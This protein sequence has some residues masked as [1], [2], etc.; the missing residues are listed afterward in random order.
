MKKYIILPIVLLAMFIL[1][2]CKHLDVEEL[3]DDTMAYD[4]LFN[5]YVNLSKYMYGTAAMFPDEG[6]I[7]GDG[8]TPG[9]LATDEGFTSM[10]KA[11]FTGLGYVLGDFDAANISS[12]PMSIW[13]DMYKIIRKSNII[14]QRKGEAK[15]TS[16]EDQE[17]TG[18]THFI[19]GY[20]YYQLLMAYGPVIL[21]KDQVYPT[22]EGAAVYNNSRSTY[23]ECVD[24]I[25]DEFELAAKNIPVDITSNFFGRPGRGA[26]FA[27]IARL[28]LQ[29][30]SPLFN[31]GQ[32]A[33]TYFGAWTRKDGVHYISQ[34]YNEKKW[35]IA[36]ASAK[37]VIDMDKYKLHTVPIDA[38]RK[39]KTLPSNVPSSAFPDGAGGIDPFRSYSEMFTGE[40]VPSRNPEFIWARMSA[41]TRDKTQH[42]F[43]LNSIFGGWNG[44]CVTQKVVDAFYM[45]DGRDKNAASTQYPYHVANNYDDS[46]FSSV[47]QTF[48][49]YI[50]PPGVFG[51]YQNREMRFY[52]S[53]G[54]SGRYWSAATSTEAAFNR[55][56]VHYHEGTGA[57]GSVYSGKNS[58]A[59]NIVD[60]PST[61][62][63]ITKYIH[64]DDA[65]KGAGSSRMDK[66][67]AMI[68]YAEILLSYAEALNQ[69]TTSHEVQLP[70]K[71]GGN[72]QAETY[73][74]AR[75]S[76]EI[77][78]YFNQVRFRSGL[79]GLDPTQ[80]SDPT[81]LQRII[82]REDMIEFLF[83]NRRYF[84]VR[85][86]GIYEES[87]KEGVYGMNLGADKYNFYRPVPVNQ[88]NNRNRIIDR[89]LVFLP[90]PQSEVRRVK[91]LD[92]NPGWGN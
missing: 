32:P 52:A 9:P 44:M 13:D 37:R 92:Q 28:R 69:L 3:F 50:L 38:S 87:E 67:F 84:D 8:S 82:Q 2:S 57:A 53:I 27:L 14:L 83:E 35:A 88:A 16:P 63:V 77:A 64:P 47:S 86:W 68:R 76:N 31:G 18:Y 15:L 42:S 70:S 25:C 81:E 6:V 90:L 21:V 11:E 75:N 5:N 24:Y 55:K 85:R 7:L 48:S 4:S 56:P 54:F 61:G 34:T 39:P 1:G 45:E 46:Y 74:V 36:A 33:R 58:S 23:D 65:W 20:A 78:K 41:S 80:I 43:P 60:Y 73:S 51:M 40:S 12:R 10:A 19:R 72:G 62:Y 22:N 91:D 89:K 49:G 79:P 59:T 26:A 71:N 29:S 30:A 17:I 66:A